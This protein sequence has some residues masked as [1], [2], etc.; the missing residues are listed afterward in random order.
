[1]QPDR[2]CAVRG[3]GRSVHTWPLH[4]SILTHGRIEGRREVGDTRPAPYLLRGG[5]M[6]AREA[7]PLP[8]AAL[9]IVLATYRDTGV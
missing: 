9:Y 7:L 8:N 1:M 5:L 2:L 3:E 4:T 6:P